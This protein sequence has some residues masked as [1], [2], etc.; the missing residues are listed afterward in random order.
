MFKY[1]IRDYK[2]IHAREAA[3]YMDMNYGFFR[4]GDE[5]AWAECLR[6]GAGPAGAPLARPD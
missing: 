1:R 6:A 4:Q 2:H 3:G 5:G